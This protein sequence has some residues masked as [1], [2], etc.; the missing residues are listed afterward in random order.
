[1]FKA[2]TLGISNKRPKAKIR[3]DVFQ[4]KSKIWPYESNFQ[5]KDILNLIFESQK[6]QKLLHSE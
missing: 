3:I 2:A 6:H 1:M 5:W 4:L